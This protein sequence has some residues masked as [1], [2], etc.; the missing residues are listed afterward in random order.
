[1]EPKDLQVHLDNQ[2][3]QDLQ[4]TQEVQVHQDKRDLKETGDLEATVG[5]KEIEGWLESGEKK[6]KLEHLGRMALLDPKV[7]L[8]HQGLMGQEEIRDQ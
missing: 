4:E 6:V 3:T 2:E 1:M 5:L 7:Q 8:V